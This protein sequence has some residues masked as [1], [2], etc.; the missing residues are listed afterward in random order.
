MKETTLTI[1]KKPRSS[2]WPIVALLLVVGFVLVLAL[3]LRAR[4]A[5]QP[6]SGAAPDFS[7][8]VY[9]G[10]D[11]GLGEPTIRLSDLRGQVVFVNFWAS[12]CVPCRE[13]QPVLE[14]LWKQYRGKGVVFVGIGYVDTEPAALQYL[15]EYNVTYP[16]GADLG[17]KIAPK[18]H[19]QGVPESFLVDRQ[20]NIVWFKIAPISEAELVAQLNRALQ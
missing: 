7:L 5:A 4:N 10:Y 9:P 16:N 6:T 20:G 14:K 18:Y 8:Q 1:A 2:A 12:W 17:V 19:I 15:K 11:G 13:E 3:A